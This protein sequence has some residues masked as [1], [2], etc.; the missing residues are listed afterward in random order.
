MVGA[1][2]KRE[3]WFGLGEQHECMGIAMSWRVTR[4]DSS[5]RKIGMQARR[6]EARR[7]FHLFSGA[8]IG[9][10]GIA[11]DIFLYIQAIQRDQGGSR[12]LERCAVVYLDLSTVWG[13]GDGF[14][15]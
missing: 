3:C 4:G 8:G 5:L 9:P 2:G 10:G 12:G 6:N 11:G 15:R 14:I 7:D 13:T 1:C